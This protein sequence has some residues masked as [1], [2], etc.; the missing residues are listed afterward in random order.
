M[1][2]RPTPAPVA[3]SYEAQ[4]EVDTQLHGRWL[5]FARIAWL[6]LVIPPMVVFLAGLPGY[7]EIEYQSY[8][9]YTPSFQQIG[10]TVDFYAS[11]YLG[12]VI[13]DAVICWSV[14]ALVLWRKSNDWMGLLTALML[15]LLRH[16]I[17]SVGASAG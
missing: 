4:H 16:A 8:L 10:I 2:S 15:V 17:H 7:R 6:A 11:Y 13:G 5:V 1:N 12:V 3:G 14:A 9:I